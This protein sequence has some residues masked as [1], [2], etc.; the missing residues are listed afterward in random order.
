V[1]FAAGGGQP[2]EA[3]IIEESLGTGETV[4]STS[5]RGVAPN[6]GLGPAA[7]RTGCAEVFFGCR[8]AVR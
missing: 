7:G 5:R 1:A 2:S 4:S 6:A 8:S 3:Q